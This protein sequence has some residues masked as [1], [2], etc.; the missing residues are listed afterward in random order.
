MAVAFNSRAEPVLFCWREPEHKG[1]H[2]DREHKVKWHEMEPGE[3]AGF[4][5]L[6]RPAPPSGDG[7]P[8]RRRRRFHRVSKFDPDE[9]MAAIRGKVRAGQ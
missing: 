8:K 5:S 4:P 7:A 3:P 2:L 1:D 6:M 9:Q